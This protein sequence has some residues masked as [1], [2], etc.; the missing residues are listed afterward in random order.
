MTF[1]QAEFDVR[2]EWGEQGV[3][4][5][6]PISDAIIIVDVM[7]F[8]TCVTIATNK[9]AIIYPHRHKDAS[10]YEYALSLN[11]ELAGTRSNSSFSLS[12]NSFFDIKSGV[13]IVLP[14][15]NGSTLSLATGKT[16]TF[17]GCLR[18]AKYVAEAAQRFGRRISVIPAG[19]RW[20]NDNTLR[21]SFEDLIGAGAIIY[22]LAGKLSPESKLALDAYI[23]NKDDLIAKLMQC[24]SGKELVEIGFK[25]D[26]TIIGQINS[27]HCAPILTNGAFSKL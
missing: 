23:A 14:S 18:N 26:V 6:A 11:A 1:D 4:S 9:G 13:R 7:S 10:M 17:A 12:P 3:L 5:L 16:T 20:R 27:D 21:P 22:H 2:C 8:S 24:S 19:E 25:D 15:P